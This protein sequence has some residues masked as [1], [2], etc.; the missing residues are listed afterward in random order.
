MQALAKNKSFVILAIVVVVGLILYRNFFPSDLEQETARHQQPIGE[1]L[2]EVSEALSRAGLSREFF[3]NQS[4][5][6]LV[7]FSS[8]LPSEPVGRKNP[9]DVIGRE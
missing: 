1:D 5:L 6:R 7:D 9:F 4:Y 8:P 2:L 3:T